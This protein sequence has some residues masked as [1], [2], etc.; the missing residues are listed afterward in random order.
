MDFLS[1]NGGDT[2]NL[3]HCKQICRSLYCYGVLI[4]RLS[5]WSNFEIGDL[6]FWRGEAYTK[7]F[8][9]LDATGGF[10]YEVG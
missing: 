10:Y 9:Y 8:E 2:Y 3:C 6:D 7:Y 1:D 5:V 4:L